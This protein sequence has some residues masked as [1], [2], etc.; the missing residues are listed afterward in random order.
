MEFKIPVVITAKITL[1]I[2]LSSLGVS[3]CVIDQSAV[4]PTPIDSVSIVDTLDKYYRASNAGVFDPYLLFDPIGDNP[5]IFEKDGF[6][7]FAHWWCL[8]R[9]SSH[10]EIKYLIASHCKANGGVVSGNWCADSQTGNPMYRAEVGGAQIV[11]DVS[12]RPC[13]TGTHVGA[14]AIE[15]YG[16][17]QQRWSQYATDIL[18]YKS[19]A[20]LKQ[21]REIAR[22]QREKEIE[23]RM[24]RMKREA[25]VMLSTRGIRICQPSPAGF[26][27]IG[28]VEDFTENKIKVSVADARFRG[29]AQPGGFKPSTIWDYPSNWMICE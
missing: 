24:E 19:P 14:L 8:D 16:Q 7:A 15:G 10:N 28:Y 9:N 22:A 23:Y 29:G 1:T 17:D 26:E 13:T 11:T 4:K 3:G 2:T 18:S 21:I 20:E 6:R 27:F 25:Q 12:S 5:G